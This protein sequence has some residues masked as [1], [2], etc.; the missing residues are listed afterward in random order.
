[1]IVADLY[2]EAGNKLIAMSFI[3]H[4]DEEAYPVSLEGWQAGF[5]WR[6]GVKIEEDVDLLEE[7]LTT[8]V[9]RPP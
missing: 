1:M 9:G 3:L 6:G 8:L 7:D 5:F 2:V 4:R